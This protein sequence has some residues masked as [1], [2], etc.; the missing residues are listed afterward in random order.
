[1]INLNGEDFAL[2]LEETNG[3]QRELRI[4]ND[5]VQGFTLRLNQPSGA[6]SSFSKPAAEPRRCWDTMVRSVWP[7]ARQVFQNCSPPTQKR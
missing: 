5:T 6:A 4:L 1:M 7:W 3:A 2:E